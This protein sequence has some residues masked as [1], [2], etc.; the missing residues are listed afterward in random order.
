MD[1]ATPSLSVICPIWN[2]KDHI[3]ETI[4]S[5]LAQSYA[6]WELVVIDGASTDGTVDIMRRYA[7]KDSRIRFYSEPDGGFWP[8]LDKGIGLSHGKYI[9]IMCGQDGFLDRDWFLRAMEIF[10]KDGEIAL[11]WALNLEKSEDGV[12][13]EKTHESYSHFV[14]QEGA[15]SGWRLAVKKAW[16]VAHDLILG[17]PMRR[18]V[19]WQ[20]I[21]S[22]TA[23]FRFNFFFKRGMPGGGVPQKEDWFRYWLDTGTVFPDESLI[24]DKRVYL[25]CAPRY[26]EIKG[27]LGPMADL[28]FNVNARGYLPWYIPMHASFGRTHSGSSGERRPGELFQNAE[29]YLK[30]VLELRKKVASDH[31]QVTFRARDGRVL[32]TKKF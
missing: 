3:A 1:G 11:V 23:F 21:F 10:E 29:N 32:A 4:D 7:E 13:K 19:L 9:T 24:I 25:E 17:D 16:S 5:V 15:A 2:V 6:N 14:E 26:G 30:K 12:L 18:K 22:K 20:K 28:Y 27:E 31:Q 8:A